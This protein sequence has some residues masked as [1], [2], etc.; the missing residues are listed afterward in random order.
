MTAIYGMGGRD[1][2]SR[3]FSLAAATSLSIFQSPPD[4][5]L[6]VNH[7]LVY[8]SPISCSP[9]LPTDSLTSSLWALT[10]SLTHDSPVS[11]SPDL[12]TDSLTGSLWALDRPTPNRSTE[13]FIAHDLPGTCSFNRPTDSLTHLVHFG[14]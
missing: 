2:F 7:S 5:C 6:P 9:D 14:H 12:P 4:S 10:H 1:I 13:S 3:Q 8:G 11:C